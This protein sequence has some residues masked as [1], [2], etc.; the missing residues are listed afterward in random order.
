MIRSNT[1]LAVLWLC[2]LLP[3]AGARGAS[4]DWARTD[5]SQVRLVSAASAA[6]AGESVRL[7]LQ[8][9]LDPGWKIYWRS[10][11]DSGSPP[12]PD[13][14]ASEN[15]AAVEVAWPAPQ[16]FRELADLETAGYVDETVLPLTL[17][18]ERPGAA[19]RVRA[20]VPYQ[21]CE[22]I[23][24]PFVAELALDLPAGEAEATPFARLIDR[25]EARTPGPPE[26]AGIEVVS[27]GVAGAPPAERLELVLRSPLPFAAPELFVEAAAPY[28]VPAG[29]ATVDDFGARARLTAPVEARGNRSLAGQAVVL[30]VVDNGR[31]IEWPVTLAPIASAGPVSLWL[32]L[33]IALLG[34][35]ILN[36]M[37]CVLPVLSLKLIGAVGH[38]GGAPGPVRVGFVAS[39][40]GIVASFLALAAAAVAVKLAGGAVGW[41][42]QFQQPAFLILLMLVLSLF[43]CNLL[44][45]F[46]IGLP[47]WLGEAGSRAGAQAGARYG[48][49]AGHFATGAFATL[50]A[51][52]CSAP[53]LGAA[54]GFALSRGALEI[55]LIFA[56][57]GLGMALPYLAVVAFPGLVTRLPRP[58]RWMLW[59]RALLGLAL[60]GTAVWLAFIL[61]AVVGG[62]AAVSVAALCA[63][64]AL[65]VCLAGRRG[66]A[67]RVA[68]GAAASLAAVAFF[69]PALAPAPDRAAEVSETGAWQ[70][71]DPA[72]L[73]EAIAGGKTVFVDVTADWCVTCAV[74]KTLVLD[75][76]PVRGRLAGPRVIAMRADWTRPNPAISAYLARFDRYGIPFNVVYGP[77]APDGIA[78]PELLRTELVLAALDRAG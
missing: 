45:L 39:A 59:V 5:V 31:A 4:S 66:R 67:W 8:F 49:L 29:S 11:G 75:A 73:R 51:T 44:G 22:K 20:T 1:V 43:A 76:E 27:V 3:A 54:V 25:Y 47:G 9:Q 71:F 61:A 36:V 33:G 58:G 57:L 50:L 40:A 69:A 68:Y 14:D 19:M 42:I 65:A 77:A 17:H 46:E 74:N 78:L 15:V 38:G 28:R 26:A 55:F 70:P 64:A 2:A 16:R 56:A 7:G 6:G 72:A 62:R 23:C 30:T 37:P 63:A 21:A 32:M 48:G 13:F 18:A 35:L 10:P 60:L 53:F 12:R 41:G 24:V 34:G 52:P